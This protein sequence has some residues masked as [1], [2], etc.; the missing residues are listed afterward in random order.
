MRFL[1]DHLQNSKDV[2][3]VKL[4]ISPLQSIV[5]QTWKPYRLL[6][7]AKA[8]PLKFPLRSLE[9]HLI[10]M[11]LRNQGFNLCKYHLQ[12]NIKDPCFL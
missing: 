10:D 5:F 7:K 11:D 8:N 3:F 1:L 4:A 9:P 2:W 6:L 12:G